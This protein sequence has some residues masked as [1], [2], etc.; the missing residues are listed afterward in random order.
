MNGNSS[1]DIQNDEV[2]FSDKWKFIFRLGGAAVLIA[3][4]FFR[5]NYAA[6][7]DAFNGF[8][9]FD[10]PETPHFQAVDWLKLL[11][12][13][14]YIGLKSSRF[15]GYF[16]LCSLLAVTYIALYG[17]LSDRSRLFM[18][19]AV[20]FSF[21]A[22]LFFTCTN[23][24]IGM[25]QLSNQYVNAGTEAQRTLILASAEAKMGATQPGSHNPGISYNLSSFLY[26]SAGL[27]S[28]SLMV[29]SK[30]FSIFTAISGILANGIGLAYF[31]LLPI[32]SPL[33]WVPPA[34]SAPFRL[35][36]YILVT[37]SLLKLGK[38]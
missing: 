12:E 29:K 24:A 2:Q 30:A 17:A 22:F 16:Q 11:G 34:L 8:G 18:G 26:Y 4:I 37:I 27:I 7:L 10:I 36:W 21:T 6:E 20:L 25:L 1:H 9:I 15:L 35:I 33:Y 3:L 31:I 23:P 13:N 32:G 19:L 28:A 38:K 5:R 14:P